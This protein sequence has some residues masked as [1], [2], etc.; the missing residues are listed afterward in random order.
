MIIE[1]GCVW[2]HG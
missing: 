2:L 1:Y